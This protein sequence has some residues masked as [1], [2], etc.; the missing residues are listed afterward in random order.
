MRARSPLCRRRRPR[1]AQ[2][3][4]SS[5]LL[6]LGVALAFGPDCTCRRGAKV[7]PPVDAAD[8][9]GDLATEPLVDA[10]ALDAAP[11]DTRIYPFEEDRWWDHR[12][13]KPGGP[14]DCKPGVHRTTI[15]GR[16]AVGG[17]EAWRMKTACGAK[18]EIAVAVEGDELATWF[19]G[20]WL[21]LLRAPL[22]DGARWPLAG[23]M[24]L[25]TREPT[26]VKVEAGTFDD[27]WT[28]TLAPE[29]PSVSTTYCRG[30]G[31]VRVRRGGPRSNYAGNDAELVGASF[32]LPALPD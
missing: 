29:L 28:V 16:R 30:V 12:Y 25:L 6:A 10:A 19:D 8:D 7:A 24:M 5:A 18:Q 11:P 23:S 22:Q 27:C 31:V 32:P 20:K 17:R 1:S 15:A 14:Y 2:R 13:A 9:A 3:R 4:R 26:P 21:H